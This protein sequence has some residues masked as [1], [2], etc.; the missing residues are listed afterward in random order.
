MRTKEEFLKALQGSRTAVFRVAE[1]V[2]RGSKGV[3]GRT[4]T[5]PHM[6]GDGP[7]SGDLFVEDEIQGTIKL[8]VKQ[9]LNH[10]FTSRETYPHDTVIVANTGTVHR[11]WGTV[12]AYVI[13]NAEMTH[14]AIVPFDTFKKWFKQE[15]HSKNT[16]QVEEYYMCPKEYVTFVKISE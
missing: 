9:K 15:I 3:K 7:D 8:E 13:T 11:N 1:W 12:V 4:I 2:H 10:H 6:E 5:I 14:A 16:D